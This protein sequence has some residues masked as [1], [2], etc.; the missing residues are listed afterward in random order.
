MILDIKK[1]LGK[2]TKQI[3]ALLNTKRIIR[4]YLIKMVW[5]TINN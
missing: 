5:I 2:N 4:N 1:I 3:N